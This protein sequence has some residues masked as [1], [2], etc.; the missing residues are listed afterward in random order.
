MDEAKKIPGT[1]E[2]LNLQTEAF[3]AMGEAI[4]KET[5][6]TNEYN[7]ALKKETEEEQKL[8]LSHATE[9]EKIAALTAEGERLRN[10]SVANLTTFEQLKQVTED[11]ARGMEMLAEADRLAADHTSKLNEAQSRYNTLQ[12]QLKNSTMSSGEKADALQKEAQGYYTLAAAQTDSLAWF[13]YESKALEDSIRLGELSSEVNRK[14]ADSITAVAN[15]QA[16]G[17]MRANLARDTIEQAKANVAAIQSQI[18]AQKAL[19]DTTSAGVEKLTILYAQ[20]AEA[21]KM[22]NADNTK[23]FDNAQKTIKESE[24]DTDRYIAQLKE[25]SA[26]QHAGYLTQQQASEAQIKSWMTTRL[27]GQDHHLRLQWLHRCIGEWHSHR[28]SFGDSFKKAT[29]SMIQ[30]IEAAILKMLI[31]DAIMAMIGVVSPGAAAAF[32][33]LSGVNNMNSTFTGAT[34]SSPPH[35]AAGG[36]VAPNTPYMIGENGPE[37]FIPGSSGYVQSNNDSTAM[38]GSVT[39]NVNI[40]TGVQQTVRAELLQYLPVIQRQTMAAVMTA[41]KRGGS[42]SKAIRGN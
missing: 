25:I 39:Q 41:T 18:S 2:A 30:Q 20:E 10:E 36:A 29:D 17:V 6:L 22:V 4:A 15:A 26:E 1:F 31:L 33:Q 23:L 14:L 24:T 27:L 11:H 34:N 13:Q 9:L 21:I 35:R 8:S 38:G 5:S 37:M 32:G 7:G 12:D 3:R 16:K 40:S 42:F 28:K 19:N